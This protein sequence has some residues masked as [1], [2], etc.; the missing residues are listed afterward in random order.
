MKNY[1]KTSI[2]IL[3]LTL[4]F[5]LGFSVSAEGDIVTDS[6]WKYEILEDSTAKITAYIGESIEVEIPESINGV[7]VSTLGSELFR[8]A[9]N[10]EKV[11]VP[12]SV[13]TMEHTFYMADSIKEIQI[14]KG[15]KE[16]VGN[17]FYCAWALEKITVDEENE[18]FASVDGVLYTK[19]MKKL[20]TVPS[21]VKAETF[22]VPDGVEILGKNAM[23]D[24][25]IAVLNLPD[26]LKTIE[27]YAISLKKLSE[28]TIPSGVE[29]MQE[30]A[31]Y[32]CSDLVKVEFKE[33]KLIEIGNM[34]FE[35]CEKLETIILP[36]NITKLGKIISCPNI[37]EYVV[38]EDNAEF[39]A[40]DGVLF[41]IDMTEIVA[42]PCGKTDESYTIPESVEI[43]GENSFY[44][45]KKLV[46][47][48]MPESIKV[49]E[50]FAFAYCS[51]LT[52]V[53][54][55]SSEAKFKEIDI[56]EETVF[57]S[58][59][60]FAQAHIHSYDSVKIIKKATNKSNGKVEYICSCGDSYSE[61]VYELDS[62]KLSTSK[63]TYNGKKRTPTVTAKDSKGNKLKKDVDYTVKYE[64]GRKLPGRYKITVSFKGKYNYTKEFDFVIMPKTP[65]LKVITTKGKAT[66]TYTD[67][68][69][70]TGYQIYYSTDGKTYKK[71]T[72][73]SKEKYT[74]TLKNGKKYYFKVRGYV[75]PSKGSTV[76]GSF[77]SVK[78]IKIK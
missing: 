18:N 50:P 34:V 33:G 75:K 25:E 17:V 29:E 44:G 60:V 47:I 35:S 71:L 19:D 7:S 63:C 48:Y 10:T 53:Y 26:S 28:L 59:V 2:L 70:V 11:I 38:S 52:T 68:T 62:V 77:S 72:T 76:Y 66:L 46:N 20:V 5:T 56:D 27:S 37:K 13:V 23:R 78:S 8:K 74:K 55:D 65:T 54:Y 24:A 32:F 3:S 61:T 16:L 30:W 69:G 4:M 67:L 51:S 22:T 58:N 14:G 41:N 21:G 9:K 31:V 40:K 39:T 49:I 6:D 57:F 36:S 73:V 43:I 64:S 45:N 1:Y 42:Y 12:D 15:L